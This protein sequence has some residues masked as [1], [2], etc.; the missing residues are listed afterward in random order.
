[1]R[2]YHPRMG[3]RQGI[4]PKKGTNLLFGSVS[5]VNVRLLCL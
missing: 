1:V 2:A 3:I 5:Q 4:Y